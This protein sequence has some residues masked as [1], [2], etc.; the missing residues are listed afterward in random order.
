VIPRG[1]ARRPGRRESRTVRRSG[2][3]LSADLD[4][5]GR[6]PGF[7][8]VRYQADGVGC[9]CCS[10]C[11]NRKRPCLS[12]RKHKRRISIPLC[13]R[14]LAHTSILRARRRRG[15]RTGVRPPDWH[16]SQSTVVRCACCR[17][18]SSLTCE[19]DLCVRPWTDPG[20]TPNA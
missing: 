19:A 1:S 7:S 10:L 8:R 3:Q 14:W 11:K 13:G 5:R 18:T 2:P 4:H 15:R 6:Q 17:L 20:E 16:G 9:G 12:V